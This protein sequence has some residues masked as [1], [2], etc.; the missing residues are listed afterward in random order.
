MK[1]RVANHAE[2]REIISA[3]SSQFTIDEVVKLLNDAGCPAS[4][5][6]T[7]DRV[8]R[9]PQIAEAREMFPEIDQPGI[10]RMKVTASAQ[11]L[12]NTKSFPRKAAPLLGEDN[13]S[14]YGRMLGF[15]GEKLARLKEQG[16]I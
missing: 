1:D 12:T 14:V 11:K 5:V 4:P 13:E 15:D 2:M 10:G 6:N 7:L 9:E 3:W 8:V 16:V